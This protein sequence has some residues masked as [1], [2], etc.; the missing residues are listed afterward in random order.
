MNATVQK[1]RKRF[2]FALCWWWRRCAPAE[3]TQR[4]LADI[5]Y[6]R[7]GDRDSVARCPLWLRVHS[8]STAVAGTVTATLTNI[9]ATTCPSVMVNWDW[10]AIGFQV[11]VERFSF[12]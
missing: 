10:N 9:M 4:L 2:V 12:R 7:I 3:R 1:N 6:A 5:H 8:F 11:R